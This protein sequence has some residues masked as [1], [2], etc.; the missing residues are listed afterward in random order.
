M[1]ST[2]PSNSELNGRSRLIAPSAAAPSMIVNSGAPHTNAIISSITGMLTKMPIAAKI[3]AEMPRPMAL[4][5]FIAI[6]VPRPCPLGQQLP[7]HQ[8]I[9]VDHHVQGGVQD[10]ERGTDRQHRHDRLVGYEFLDG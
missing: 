6:S 2:M 7:A 3:S 5:G 10:D 8:V 9:D 1:C 4:P